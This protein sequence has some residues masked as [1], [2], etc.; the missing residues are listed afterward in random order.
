M[1][2]AFLALI[3][4]TLSA[5]NPTPDPQTMN[6]CKQASDCSYVVDCCGCQALVGSAFVSTWNERKSLCPKDLLCEN[7]A[8]LGKIVACVNNSCVTQK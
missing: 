8:H 6:T 7:C 4:L 5:C 1:R 3:L 2:Y